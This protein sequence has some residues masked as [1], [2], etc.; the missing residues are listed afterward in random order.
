MVLLLPWIS[1]ALGADLVPATLPSGLGVNI[2]F[3]QPRAGE[4]KMLKEAG[5]GFVRM[6][7]DWAQIEKEKGKY[8][9]SAYDGL[10]KELD[11][12]GIGALFILDYVNPLY[13]QGQ[14]PHTEQR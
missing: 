12:S 9:F 2:H 11:A 14:S 5:F 6:D 3:T 10:M 7:F 8:D 4:M 13:D 1:A